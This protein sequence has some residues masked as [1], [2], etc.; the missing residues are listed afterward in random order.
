MDQQGHFG[1]VLDA[2][3]ALSPEEQLTL[4]DIVARRL[5]EEGRKRVAADI[6]ESRKDFAEGR[7]ILTTI[8]RL[9]DEILS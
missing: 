9:R 1:E 6:Q 3:G 8:D 7:C 2:V 5:A 4:V